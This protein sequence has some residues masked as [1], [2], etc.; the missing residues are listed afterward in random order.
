MK[1]KFLTPVVTAFNEYGKLDYQANQ[2]IY[3]HLINGGIDG[4]VLMG[5]TGEFFT[6]SMEQKKELILLA[7]S[8]INKRVPLLIGT[9]CMAASDTIELANFAHENGADGVLV[10][11][12]YYFSLSD[13][14][15]EHYFDVVAESCKA[16]IYMY[17]FPDRTGYDISPEIVLKLIRKH[18]NIVGYKDTITTLDHTRELIKTV[19]PEF[20]DFQIFCGYDDNFA[21][22]ILSGG[23]GCIGGL[24]NLCPEVFAA[25]ANAIRDENIEEISY[26]QK[27][28]DQLTTLYSVGT[29]FIPY[30]KKAM[31]MRGVEMKDYCTVPFL[32]AN[33]EQTKKIAALLEKTNLI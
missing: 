22:N 11:P 19:K 2:N 20:P 8:Y 7:T 29:P 26:Y 28:V 12:P 30:V 5:S 23:D 3:D 31:I 14:S 32:P 24:S 1:A 10:I 21:H 33:E 9:S 18:K 13:E 16:N 4:I 27:L 15:V 17:N 25:W 6:M